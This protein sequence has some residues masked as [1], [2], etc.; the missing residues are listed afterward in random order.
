MSTLIIRRVASEAG[1]NLSGVTPLLG[2]RPHRPERL[3]LPFPPPSL[4]AFMP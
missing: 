2:V 4:T 3:A 1:F